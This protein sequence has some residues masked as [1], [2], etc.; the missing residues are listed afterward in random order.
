MYIEETK[1]VEGIDKLMARLRREKEIDN[2]MVKVR[3]RPSEAIKHSLRAD[4]RTLKIVKRRLIDELTESCIGL[5]E[6]KEVVKEGKTKGVGYI[7]MV[8]ALGAAV[9]GST[10]DAMESSTR[11]KEANKARYWVWRTLK[12]SKN[13]Y[14]LSTMAHLF[15][16]DHSTVLAGLKTYDKDY[17]LTNSFKEQCDQAN[18]LLLMFNKKK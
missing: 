12:D 9:F 17:I 18:E 8:I 14:T 2:S 6:F 13:D 4:I 15:N 7:D 11:K 1:T 16:R 10:R 3:A 5:I